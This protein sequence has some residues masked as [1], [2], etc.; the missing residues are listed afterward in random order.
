MYNIDIYQSLELTLFISVEFTRN[1]GVFGGNLQLLVLEHMA[2]LSRIAELASV[3]Q[4]HTSKVD[5]YISS[6]GLESPSFDVSMPA[7]LNLPETVQLSSNT[8]I[9]AT[10]EL[11]S[12][13]LGPMGFLVHQIESPVGMR[14]SV[15]HNI[16]A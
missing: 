10:S 12:L 11:H 2:S 9:E 5:D 14:E 15:Y 16:Q 3:I 7:Q 13:M 8:V 4:K 6:H 1:W